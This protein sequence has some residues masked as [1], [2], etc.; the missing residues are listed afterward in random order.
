MRWLGIDS[1]PS[2]ARSVQDNGCAERFIRLSKENLLWPE[3]Q[4]CLEDLQRALQRFKD[5]YNEKWLVE[6]C[7]YRSPGQFTRDEDATR[8]V[9]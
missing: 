3:T 5:K 9:A 6:R 2:F 4:S 8:T 7:R 1:S